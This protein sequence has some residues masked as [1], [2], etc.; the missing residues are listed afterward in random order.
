[1]LVKLLTGV[2]DPPPETLT[3][4]WLYLVATLIATLVGVGLALWLAERQIER[5]PVEVLRQS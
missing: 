1:M 4:P 5:S 2:F 3:V